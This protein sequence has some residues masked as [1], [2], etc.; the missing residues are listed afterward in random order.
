LLTTCRIGFKMDSHGVLKRTQFATFVS[1]GGGCR[2]RS[3]QICQVDQ[4]H[5]L[6]RTGSKKTLCGSVLPKCR[7]IHRV[8]VQTNSFNFRTNFAVCRSKH[9][10]PGNTNVFKLI[11]RNDLRN[12]APIASQEPEPRGTHGAHTTPVCRQDPRR[13]VVAGV[14]SVS[15]WGNAHRGETNT[16]PDRHAPV[17]PERGH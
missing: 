5:R 12:A 4:P 1:W 8:V 6:P 7:L 14:Q 10:H 3:T 15:G 9:N 16:R 17:A 13:T 2:H 11:V